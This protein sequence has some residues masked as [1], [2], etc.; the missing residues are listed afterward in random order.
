MLMSQFTREPVSVQRSMV[1]AVRSKLAGTPGFL[2]QIQ[3]AVW[4]VNP[5][6][7]LARV[8]TL[9]EISATSMAQTSFAT[10]MLAVAASVALLLGV[11][12]IY[13]V[14]AYVVTQR[15]RE[16]GI[17]IALGAQIGDVRRLFLHRGL[18]LISAGI[19]LGIVVALS[20]TRVMSALLFGVSPV[21][22][23]TYAAVSIGLAGVAVLATW[24]PT[25]R[26]SRVDPVVALR[27]GM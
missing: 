17:R 3:Q 26:A 5:N 11:V 2:R 8:R 1:Y 27:A 22:P 16:I 9:D 13:G 25:R 7:P 4:S 12:G 15:T 18:L 24:L 6:L 23:A 10:V 21:D 19:I 14:I 20:L